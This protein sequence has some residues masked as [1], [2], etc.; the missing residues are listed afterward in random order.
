MESDGITSVSNVGTTTVIIP[1]S[2]DIF[3]GETLIRTYSKA[4]HGDNFADLAASYL[5]GHPFAHK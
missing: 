5:A 1:E 2:I 3:Q 4:E